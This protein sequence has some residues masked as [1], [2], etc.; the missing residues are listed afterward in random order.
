MKNIKMYE[1]L[2]SLYNVGFCDFRKL[3]DVLFCSYR[4]CE[5]YTYF[6]LVSFYGASEKITLSKVRQFVAVKYGFQS[7]KDLIKEAR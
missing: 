6:M 4:K 3:S 5:P 1:D 2:F 7:W